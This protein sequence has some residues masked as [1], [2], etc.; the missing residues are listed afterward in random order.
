MEERDKGR[1][2]SRAWRRYQAW[3][4]AGSEAFAWQDRGDVMEA[5]SVMGLRSCGADTYMCGLVLG[6]QQK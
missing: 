5:L 3:R 6:G 4:D 1:V 2:S